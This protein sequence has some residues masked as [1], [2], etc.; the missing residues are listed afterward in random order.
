M[1]LFTMANLIC[2]HHPYIWE[3][4][5]SGAYFIYWALKTRKPAVRIFCYNVA[6]LVFCFGLLEAGA[7]LVNGY[8]EEYKGGWYTK[9]RNHVSDEILGDVPKKNIRVSNIKL[10]NNKLVYDVVYTIN[11]DGLR[12]TPPCVGSGCRDAV[13]FFGCSYTFGEGLNDDE[14]LPF[15]VGEAT[16]R[17]TYNFGLPGYGPHQMLSAID[18]GLVEKL[19]D[20]KPKY[21]ICQTAAFHIERAAGKLPWGQHA[22]KYALAPDGSVK[23][24]GHFDD[25]LMV[26]IRN[27]LLQSSAIYKNFFEWRFIKAQICKDKYDVERYMAIV[28]AAKDKLQQKYPGL[29]FDIIYWNDWSGGYVT[30]LD[31][32]ITERFKNEGIKVH[33]VSEILPDFNKHCSYYTIP[34][35]G[36]PNSLA[37]KYLANY[38]V[39]N[40][41]R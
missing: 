13:L 8:Q 1:V 15:L 7:S 37:N 12:A 24:A 4:L 36:H 23:Y 6:V 11:K 41:V 39:Q 27:H 5:V 28:I 30:E 16:R 25:S 31:R 40:I 3:A 22:P 35:D 17:K 29:E 32:K 2:S 9:V 18:H 34:S 21:A 10:Y 19:V 33:L 14:T 26:R 38:I 20:V